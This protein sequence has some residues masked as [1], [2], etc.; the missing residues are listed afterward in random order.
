[1][2]IPTGHVLARIDSIEQRIDKISGSLSQPDNSFASALQNAQAPPSAE[3]DTDPDGNPVQPL[4]PGVQSYQS[5]IRAAAAKYNIDPK[6]VQSVMEVESGG[7]AQAVSKA[8]A[9]G[10]MQLMPE[11]VSEAG[12]SNPFDPAQNI[13]AGAKQLSDVLSQ[14]GGNVPLAL[15]AY[16]AGPNAVKRY[17][18]VPPYPETQHYIGKVQ[19][20]MANP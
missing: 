12:I 17:G 6:L 19:A 13:D 4:S 9:L 16:N 5:L 8:G 3:P 20:L 15:A 11:N 10:L 14:F 2:E 7:N 1:M 18:G